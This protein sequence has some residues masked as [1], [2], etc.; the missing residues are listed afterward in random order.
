M[1]AQSPDSPTASLT[2]WDL[3]PAEE[4]FRD[5]F[6][7]WLRAEME[8]PYLADLKGRSVTEFFGI[9][10]QFT[11]RLGGAGYLGIT[12]PEAL[13]GRGRSHFEQAL[14][15]AEMAW[16][17]APILGQFVLEREVLPAL[18]NFGTEEQQARLIPELL[19][20]QAMIS[21]LFTEPGTGSDLASVSTK[22][23]ESG[24]GFVIEG[25][26]WLNSVAQVAKYLWIVART[27]PGARHRG[28]SMFLIPADTPGVTIE[29]LVEM[30]SIHRLN[31]ITL[32]KVEV[33]ADCL[34]GGLNRGWDIAMDTVARERA[35]AA[36][37]AGIRRAWI[38]LAEELAARAGDGGPDADVRRRMARE[39]VRTEACDLLY[40]RYARQ[41]DDAQPSEL[42]GTTLKIYGDEVEQDL[43]DLGTELL[44]RDGVL[45]IDDRAPLLGRL[46]RL[47]VAA[48]GF[49]LGGGTS[50]ILRTVIAT[51]NL[52]LPREPSVLRSGGSSK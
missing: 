39:A 48:P 41:S 18:V 38:D 42:G 33:P 25:Q 44:G 4:A 52:G 7:D 45:D 23:T 10:P 50:E 32:D 34:I 43:G 11:A 3:T 47:H 49:S 8:E 31:R 13:G 5:E 16:Y 21:Q 2:E 1:N 40:R 15:Q 9:E 12:T 51:R 19:S 17:R 22:A 28:L 37:P 36:R 26:K 14:I 24:D 27:D 35:G 20:G 29:P 46:A 6:R 30:T